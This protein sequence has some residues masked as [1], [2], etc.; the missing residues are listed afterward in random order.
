MEAPM[1]DFFPGFEHRQIE[2]TGATINLVTGG[3]GPALLLLY[4]YPQTHV[5]WRKV[6]ARLAQDFTVVVPDLRGYGTSRWPARVSSTIR[7]AR[8]RWIRSR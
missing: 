7:N 2:T 5:M 6:A 4:G 3:G 8:W 1:P